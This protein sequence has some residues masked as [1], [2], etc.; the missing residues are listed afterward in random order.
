MDADAETRRAK[1]LVFAGIAF[2]ISSIFVYSELMYL[3]RGTE[4]TATIKEVSRVEK[5]GR[6]GTSRGHKLVIDY[7]FKDGEGRQR[8]GSDQV[9]A[10]WAVPA[11][12]RVQIRYRPGEDGS[13]RLAG[14]VSWG[15]III[16]TVCLVAVGIF[17]FRLWREATEETKGSRK[18]RR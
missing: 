2:L 18:R 11:D 8:E 13:S 1:Y 6:F 5:R 12:R 4:T 15:A 10:D 3:I 16:F 17:G 14:H 9:D 7:E